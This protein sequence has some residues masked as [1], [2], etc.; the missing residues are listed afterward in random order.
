MEKNIEHDLINKS[1]SFILKMKAF[2]PKS[3][4]VYF[5]IYIMKLIPLMVITHDWN[6]TSKYSTSFWIRKITLSEII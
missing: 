6:L 5:L 4:R 1:I 3:K 2:F